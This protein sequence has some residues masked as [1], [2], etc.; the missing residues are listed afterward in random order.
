MTR[1]PTFNFQLFKKEGFFESTLRSISSS[2]SQRK[3]SKWNSGKRARP[4][5]RTMHVITIAV[6]PFAVECVGQ[7]SDQIVRAFRRLKNV[8]IQSFW[9][10]AIVLNALVF[11]GHTS[12]SKIN[13]SGRFP[14]NFS[15]FLIAEDDAHKCN[16]R[17]CGTQ[18]ST[19]CFL[20]PKL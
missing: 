7:M 6:L 1:H 11:M 2:P 4:S 3:K 12:V 9:P 16:K 19:L 17:R 10:G 20:K 18:G 5:F 14:T 15:T 8:S 13:R